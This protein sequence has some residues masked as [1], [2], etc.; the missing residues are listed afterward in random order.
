[1]TE[2]CTYEQVHG[3]VVPDYMLTGSSDRLMTT[4]LTTNKK[5]GG[6]SKV[7]GDHTTR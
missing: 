2:T 1:M 7:G 6:A 5:G 4:D 3:Q